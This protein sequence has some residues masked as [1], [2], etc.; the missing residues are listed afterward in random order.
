M[1][2]AQDRFVTKA[3]GIQEPFDIE[4]LRLSLQRAGATEQAIERILTDTLNEYTPG[5]STRKIYKRAFKFLRKKEKPHA[6]RYKLKQAIMELGPSGFPFER[7][8]GALLDSLGYTSQVGQIVQGRCVQ[9]EIDVV[10]HRAGMHILVECKYHNQ[11]GRISD[12]KVPLYIKARFDDI[13]ERW[14]QE[15][16]PQY[17]FDKGWIFTNTRFSADALKYGTCAGLKLISWDFPAKEN[18]RELIDHSGL[19]PLTSLTSL[20]KTEKQ[21]LLTQGLVLCKEVLQNPASLLQAGIPLP[22]HK[23]IYLEVEALLTE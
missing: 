8:V 2:T 10:A 16:Q 22:R 5:I 4:K 19:F 20:S 1:I 21:Q 9:H 6:A 7:L 11:P 3:S 12:V 23:A 13:R 18:L 17:L 15:H 14:E